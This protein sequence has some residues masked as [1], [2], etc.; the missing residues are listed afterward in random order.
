MRGVWPDG[1]GTHGGPLNAKDLREA[2][3]DAQGGT[4]G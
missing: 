4:L 1:E 3:E 2:Q